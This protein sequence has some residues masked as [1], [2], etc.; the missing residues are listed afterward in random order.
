[1][2]GS[3]CACVLGGGEVSS[4]C[5]HEH[6]CICFCMVILVQVCAWRWKKTQCGNGIAP[7]TTPP[8]AKTNRVTHLV[9]FT[10]YLHECRC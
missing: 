3:V 7:K 10:A 8:N 6:A 4:L 9:L 2:C 5:V 1:M